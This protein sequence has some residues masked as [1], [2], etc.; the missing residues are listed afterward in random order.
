M[1][2]ITKKFQEEVIDPHKELY[3]GITGAGAAEAATRAAELQL[4]GTREGIEELRAGREQ[5]YE[6]LSPFREAGAAQLGGLSQLISDPQAQLRYVQENP[7]FQALAEQSRQAT[8]SGQA[9]GGKLGTG[10]TLAELEKRRLLLGT[11][12]VGQN[13]GQRMNLATL[14]ANAAAGQATA[15]QQSSRGIS[16]LIGSGSAAQA[17]GVVGAAN[18][19]QNALNQLLQLGALSVSDRRMKKDIKKIGE[20]K[21]PV[22]S[23]KYI[24]NEDEQIGYMAQDVE[25]VYPEAVKEID[26][27]KH[28]D[29]GILRKR[30]AH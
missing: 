28:I 23:F 3:E 7:F 8:L 2:D 27:V 13:I 1:V 12:L 16:D 18:A 29:Y 6:A 24:W 22:Y 25:K 9:A 4:Q 21:F 26:G 19:R 10:G 15:T 5:A 11:E 17:A 14:G 20:Y 30:Y